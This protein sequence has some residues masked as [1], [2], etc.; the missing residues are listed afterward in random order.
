MTNVFMSSQKIVLYRNYHVYY[1][2]YLYHVLLIFFFL[3]YL[4]F[5]KYTYY[6]HRLSNYL[7]ISYPKPSSIF[8]IHLKIHFKRKHLIALLQFL[9]SLHWLQLVLR[10]RLL[11]Q[12]YIS[13]LCKRYRNFK[14]WV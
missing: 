9:L 11:L 13:F 4:N 3:L 10:H 2:I 7:T 1:Y 14:F 12:H 5:G 6:K 8:A